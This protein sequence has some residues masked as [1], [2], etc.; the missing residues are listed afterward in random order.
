MSTPNPGNEEKP[1]F[2]FPA[3]HNRVPLL[4]AP[5]L[6]VA[7]IAVIA[8]IWYWFSPWFTDVGYQP[9]QPVAYSH[10]LHAGDLAIDC[11]YCHVGVEKGAHAGVPPT[12]TC[13]NCHTN[14]KKDSPYLLPVRESWATGK[15]VEWVR[16]HKTPDYAYFDHSIHV[17]AAIGCETCHGR[18]DQMVEVHQDQPLSM[19]WCLDCH[20]APEN[21]L[22]PKGTAT[23]M[24]YVAA[25]GDQL[26][27]GEKIKKEAGINPP[28]NCSGCHR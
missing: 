6:A 8:A 15:P 14:V 22:R 26:A 1:L 11:R 27:L 4:L 3:F 5:V 25:G 2:V 19:S 10:K 24:G 12:Q 17:N 9:E 18:I 16:I 23:V 20:K 21:F 28:I 7:P 13:M